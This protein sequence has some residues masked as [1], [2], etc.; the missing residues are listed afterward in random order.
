MAGIYTLP[1]SIGNFLMTK[2]DVTKFMESMIEDVCIL[3]VNNT[4]AD[5]VP[6]IVYNEPGKCFN[7]DYN[8]LV[9]SLSYLYGEDGIKNDFMM[10]DSM[11]KSMLTNAI[12]LVSGILEKYYGLVRINNGKVSTAKY[13]WEIANYCDG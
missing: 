4:E 1:I 3:S 13:G 2:G 7:V 10:T 5:F 9:H 6:P 12:F 11:D 8:F